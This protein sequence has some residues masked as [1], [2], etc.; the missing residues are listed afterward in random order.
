MQHYF[1]LLPLAGLASPALPT[2]GFAP[3]L[4]LP[5]FAA[6]SSPSALLG[7]LRNY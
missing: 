4:Q 7:G 1:L 3:V 6:I 2:L 5:F